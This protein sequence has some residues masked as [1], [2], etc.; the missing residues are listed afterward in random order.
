MPDVLGDLDLLDALVQLRQGVD[1]GNGDQVVAAEA[2]ALVLDA[3]LLVGALDARPA[4]ERV[5]ADL[6]RVQRF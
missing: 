3:A 6:P 4:V 2:S 1:L 5:E